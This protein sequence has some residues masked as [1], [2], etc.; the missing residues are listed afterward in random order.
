MTI[1]KYA[2]GAP[3]GCP[4]VMVEGV[5]LAYSDTGTGTPLVCLHATG[6]GARDFEGLPTLLTGDVRVI[7]VD[8]PGHGRSSDDTIPASALRYS[9]LIGGILDH[10][11]IERAVILGN[12]IGGAAALQFAAQN[13]DRVA[14][15]ILANPGGLL[16]LNGFT[17][18]VCGMMESFFR[19]G[20]KKRIWFGP[21]FGAYYRMVLRKGPIAEHRARIVNAGYDHAPVLAQAWHSFALPDA[22]I[23]HL[24][25]TIECSVLVTWARHDNVIQYRQCRPAIET[26][27]RAKTILFNG[28]HCAFL[29]D[30]EVF[31]QAADSFLARL[32]IP[33]QT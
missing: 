14:G 7:A 21:A 29:E 17:R 30:A 1:A 3:E 26:F 4:T 27:P 25:P 2:V 15:L 24:L 31:G 32:E 23:R 13:P 10:L 20:E 11:D 8:W 18:A 12:S 28:G 33:A 22:D 9:N 19:A 5:R 6:H 16:P